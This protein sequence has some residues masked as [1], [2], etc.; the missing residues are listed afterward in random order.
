MSLSTEREKPDC[1]EEA[2]LVTGEK[3]SRSLRPS[4]AQS[5]RNCADLDNLRSNCNKLLLS[6][7][8]SSSA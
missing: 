8:L 6:L 7:S 1:G 3:S 2:T 5:A 4:I